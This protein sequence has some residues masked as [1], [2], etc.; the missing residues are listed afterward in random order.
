M[1]WPEAVPADVS[2]VAL[3]KHILPDGC[4]DRDK[5]RQICFPFFR[6]ITSTSTT[7][8]MMTNDE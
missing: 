4:T 3:C 6:G 8:T 7:Q 5:M 1:R 2:A